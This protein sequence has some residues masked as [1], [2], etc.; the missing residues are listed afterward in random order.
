MRNGRTHLSVTLPLIYHTLNRKRMQTDRQREAGAMFLYHTRAPWPVI[1]IFGKVGL[2]RG[3]TLTANGRKVAGKK[4][5]TITKIQSESNRN[6]SRR[7]ALFS[8]FVHLKERLGPP[9]WPSSSPADLRRT[10][11]WLEILTAVLDFILH[12]SDG[13]VKKT[14]ATA[15]SS[16]VISKR[17]LVTS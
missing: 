13:P 1:F 4:L 14:I 2:L 8:W 15:H 10:R 11:P 12:K 17:I 3:E 6:S 9:P 7:E 5:P 16:E